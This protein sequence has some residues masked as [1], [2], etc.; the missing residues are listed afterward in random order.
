MKFCW[1]QDMDIFSQ[2]GG[3]QNTDR[4]HFTEGIRRGHDI[5][6][7][8]PQREINAV[9]LNEA[10][11]ISNVTAFGIETFQKLKNE[12]RPYI[13]F[14]H[15]YFC[16]YRLF[17]PM[18]AKC[19]QCY[20]KERWLPILLGAKLL[21]WL[22][23]LH[24]NSWLWSYPELKDMPHAVVPSPV[25]PKQFYEMGLPR[26]NIV[27]VSS[28]F[29]FK[30]R[31]NVLRWAIEHPEQRV[32]FIS[33]N[34][35]PDEPLPPNC[36]DI[37]I[38]SFWALNEIYNRHKTF[39]HLPGTPMPFDRAVPE[40]F[41]AGCDIIGNKLIGALSYPWFKSRDEVAKHC[42]NSSKLFWEE[43]ENALRA[44]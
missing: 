10:V 25:D 41:L 22:S 28:L 8:T 35:L 40:A 24:R 13:W 16:K 1:A 9:F 2:G 3:S 30:G 19:K 33:G 32:T 21:I 42:G 44:L 5:I 34:P 12:A 36:Q 23:P 26:E 15:D 20:L 17:Y 29:P 11:I 39:L 7:V 38:Q 6:L 18:Q 4:A 14:F 27:S 43:I 37:G 31:E